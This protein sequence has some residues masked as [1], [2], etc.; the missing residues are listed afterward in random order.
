MGEALASHRGVDMVAFTG[1]SETGKTIMSLASV[2]VKRLQLELGGKNPAIILD[3]ADINA[4]ANG[5]AKQ[6]TNNSGQ[7]CDLCSFMSTRKYMTSSWK[8]SQL[9]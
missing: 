5:M 4:A 8:S 9:R 7:I 2:T 1:S 6:Q 3:D